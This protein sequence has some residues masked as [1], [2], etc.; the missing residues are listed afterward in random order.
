ML[1]DVELHSRW[2]CVFIYVC[3]ILNCSFAKSHGFCNSF[4]HS[5]QP[6]KEMLNFLVG[7]YSALLQVLLKA[8]LVFIW[9]PYFITL[10]RSL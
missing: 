2:S 7:C 5:Y 4:V 9:V 3:L 8:V 6:C 10:S 1:C